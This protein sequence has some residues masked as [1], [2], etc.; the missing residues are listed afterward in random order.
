MATEE[1]LS[2][3]LIKSTLV[4]ANSRHI[5][6]DNAVVGMLALL[7]QNVVSR[8]HVIHDIGL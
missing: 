3:V 4:V 1:D 6:D 8:D 5:L 7:V 2:V